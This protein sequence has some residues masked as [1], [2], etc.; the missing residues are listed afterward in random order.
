MQFNALG[1]IREKTGLRYEK[2]CMEI[3]IHR[4]P[5]KATVVMQIQCFLGHRSPLNTGCFHVPCCVAHLEP[6][7]Q[8]SMNPEDLIGSCI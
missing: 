2:S 3:S 8:V 1:K 4:Y 5:A 7:G 6:L